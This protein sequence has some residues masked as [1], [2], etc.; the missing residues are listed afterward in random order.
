MRTKASGPLTDARIKALRPKISN[1][2]GN[3]RSN[4]IF[5][6]VSK[7]AV[8]GLL[9][10]CQPNGKKS[11]NYQ[12]RRPAFV[13]N[14]KT[15]ESVLNKNA[16]TRICLGRTDDITI[17]QARQRARTASDALRAARR[18]ELTGDNVVRKVHEVLNNLDEP[19]ETL[20]ARQEAKRTCPTVEQFIDHKYAEYKRTDEGLKTFQ[21][22][23][24]IQRLKY[25][26]AVLSQPPQKGSQPG[27]Q[28]DP[29]LNLLTKKLDEID[30]N[31]IRKWKVARLKRP[32]DRTGKPPSRVTVQRELMMMQAM[33][34][35]AYAREYI[36]SNP[37]MENRRNK[38]RKNKKIKSKKREGLL[39]N[40][41]EKR[42]NQALIDREDRLRQKRR[43]ANEFA[44][45]EGGRKREEFPDDKFVDF[46]RPIVMIAIN[47]GLRFG[48][49]ASLKWGDVHL[50]KG[51]S[52]DRQNHLEIRDTKNDTNLAMPL[53][54][55]AV[56][57]LRK[58]KSWP[59]K[60]VVSIEK[61]KALVFTNRK[62]NKLVDIRHHWKPV[63][64]EA[65]LPKGYRFHDLRHHFASKLVS[66][67]HP[68]FAV[69]ALLNHSNPQMTQRYAHHDPEYLHSVVGS[70]TKDSK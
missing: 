16:S 69:Q 1:E 61:K 49:I 32:S 21:D 13:K 54:P 2:T 45:K 25:I 12:F 51:K 35:E 41:Q 44:A 36:D 60:N 63:F 50:I 28:G 22:G 38:H 3:K 14:R 37:L 65:G 62:G 10:R 5:D 66:M 52:D 39:T 27:S 48:E 9:V 17:K 53:N 40:A 8:P 18:A 55:D 59:G 6:A 20:E 47:T 68:L 31:L 30:S 7:S 24:E 70:L 33:F 23:R 29:D 26:L 4:S 56:R 11:F 57:V 64:I 19:V 43:A 34:N 58:W 15:G 46:L 42:L 67:G